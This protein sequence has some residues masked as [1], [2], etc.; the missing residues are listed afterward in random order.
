MI[1]I[2]LT[3]KID[4]K[5]SAV[6]ILSSLNQINELNLSKEEKQ[7]AQKKLKNTDDKFVQIKSLSVTN[8]IVL[9]DKKSPDYKDFERLRKNGNKIFSVI[10]EDKT[11]KISIVDYSDKKSAIPLAEGIILSSYTFLKYFK[12]K[13]KKELKLKNL[14]IVSKSVK[15]KD[16]VNLSSCLTG[17]FHA[18]DIVNEPLSYM[19]AKQ[20][21]EEIKIIGKNS[22]FKV[23]VFDKKRIES[24]KMGGLLAVNRGSIDP[25]TF[26][27]LTWAPANAINDRPYVLVGKGL[28]YDTGGINLKPGSGLETMKSDKSGAA[29]VIGAFA[30][31]SK[32]KL[33]IKIIGLI[34]ATDNRPGNNAYVP[35]DIIKMYDGTTVEVL[36]TD[37]EGRMILADALAYAKKYNPELV[38]DVATL[39]GAAVVA[40]GTQAT[41]VMGND[42]KNIEKIIKTGFDTYE[43]LVELPLWEDYKEQL[44]SDFADLKNIGG[45]WAGSITAGKFLE[46]FTDYKWIHLDIAGPAFN[47]TYSSY[48]GKGGTG[49]G[50]RLLFNFFTN[51]IN[52]K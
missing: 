9:S 6:F 17:V 38:I 47:E 27:I 40:I 44:K 33:P 16:I 24:L 45:R 39:T 15:K 13:K 10:S 5:S 28:V 21:S 35:Q 1:K 41:A 23:E 30:A 25:P 18:R 31:I 43:R 37:A 4:K 14:E 52:N 12:D 11:E 50:V 7:F 20:L 42:K 51:K 2:N 8:F 3:D 34:P 32:A 46:H 49:V 22:G 26:S 19:S 29:A 48:N 36:N